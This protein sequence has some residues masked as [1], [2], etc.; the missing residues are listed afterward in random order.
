MNV[1][2]ND[3]IEKLK[4]IG[5]IVADTLVLM[6][7]KAKPG[8]TSKELDEIG[9]EYLDKFGAK[10]A[11]KVTYNFPGYT[12]ISINHKIAHGI[13]SETKL[14]KG[15]LINIDVSAELDGYFA[16]TGG[17]F[18]LE[19]T[20]P[21]YERLCKATI[22]SMYAGIFAAKANKKISDIGK[23]IQKTAKSY[24]YNIIEN[25][26]S[27]GVGKALHEEPKFISSIYD[28]NDKRIL[29]NGSVITVEPFL[30]NG[31]NYAKE[32]QDGWTLYINK[33]HR[34]AQFEHSIIVTDREPIILTIPSNGRFF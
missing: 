14:K 3:E 11:P 18:T 25:L 1:K 10:S 31:S 7:E 28:D 16:D 4:N 20:N 17:T 33:N 5:Q 13:P 19:N 6:K 34:A 32:S 30:S 29:S 15:D 2:S 22:D 23:A 27:H 21:H 26:G 8:M 12:C 24:N 9:F